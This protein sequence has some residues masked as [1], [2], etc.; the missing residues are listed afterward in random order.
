MEHS[1]KEL[2]FLEILIKNKNGQIILDIYHKLTDT[3]QY[4]H[5]NSHHPKNCLKSIPYTLVQRI[6]TII[7]NK[8]LRKIR[9]KELH[10]ILHQRGY[11]T[12]LINKGFEL[13]EKN[14]TKITMKKNITTKKPYH[15]SQLWTI[16]RNNKK[17]RT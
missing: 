7:T 9:L 14:T 16:H 4:R 6:C 12:T 11:P 1:S 5:F 3:Q 10:T 17:S 15:M 8:N 13:A 2:P